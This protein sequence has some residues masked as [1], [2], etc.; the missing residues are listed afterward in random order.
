MDLVSCAGTGLVVEV[1]FF[2]AWGLWALAWASVRECEWGWEWE[3]EWFADGI[4]LGFVACW[5][6]VLM[7]RRV[8]V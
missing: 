7:G 4:L 3:W 5:S 6:F 2:E 1:G 8:G